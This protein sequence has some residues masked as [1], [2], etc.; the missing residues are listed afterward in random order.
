MKLFFFSCILFFFQSCMGQADPSNL[1]QEAEAKLADGTATTSDMLTDDKY[2]ALHAETSFRELIKKYAG[3]AALTISAAGEP[4]KK[5]KVKAVLK[6]DSGKPLADVTVYLYQTDAKGWY[7][8]DRP[9]ITGNGGDRMHARL[10]GYVKTDADGK[11]ELHT[12]KP[13]GYPQSDLPAHIHVEIVGVDG[14]QTLITEFL[15]DDDERLAGEIRENSERNRFLIAKPEPTSSP[16]DQQ[17]SYI[18][19]LSER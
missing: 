1:L 8:A 14:Y 17:F 18:L 9:H 2:A 3:A 4:G 13:S 6:N 5:I 16:F 10:F 11:F 7:A 19:S 12:I 15:F